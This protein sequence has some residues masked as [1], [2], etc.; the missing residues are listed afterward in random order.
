MTSLLASYFFL[1][2]VNFFSPFKL[3]ISSVILSNSSFFLLTT[4]S[5]SI[6]LNLSFSNLVSP[7]LSFKVINFSFN[8]FTSSLTL[9]YSKF[10]SVISLAINATSILSSSP[11][12]S[13]YFLATTL[14]SFKGRTVLDNSSMTSL[15]RIKF[16]SVLSNFFKLSS[17]RF[18]YFNT[19]AALSNITLLSLD[20]EF[21]I[22]VTF[23]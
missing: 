13:R 14:C 11:F 6:F 23:P 17:L 8:A 21:T 10:K 4:S 9:E 7:T 12:I 1:S 15:I 19:P 20:L 2:K 22:S 18:L 16:S 3:L 5:S